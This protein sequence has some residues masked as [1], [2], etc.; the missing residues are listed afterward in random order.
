MITTSRL[1]HAYNSYYGTRHYASRTSC[2]YHCDSNQHSAS[3][4]L[5]KHLCSIGKLREVGY[6]GNSYSSLC[7]SVSMVTFCLMAKSVF[8]Q[9]SR[10]TGKSEKTWKIK[11]SGKVRELICFSKTSGNKLYKC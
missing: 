8:M 1:H 5:W 11:S 4:L 6:H 2:S 3:W 9:V 7:K 10:W